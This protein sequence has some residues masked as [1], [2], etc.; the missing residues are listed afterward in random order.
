M[1]DRMLSTKEV[2][3]SSMAWMAKMEAAWGPTITAA[4][5][6]SLAILSLPPASV[7]SR[8]MMAISIFS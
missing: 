4:W 2:S 3:S 7:T 5:L 1:M 8:Y 6:T